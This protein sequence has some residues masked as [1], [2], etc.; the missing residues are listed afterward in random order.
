MINDILTKWV[1]PE[2]SGTRVYT[3][4]ICYHIP[5]RQLAIITASQWEIYNDV[6]ILEWQHFRTGPSFNAACAGMFGRFGVRI[7]DYQTGMELW[8]GFEPKNFNNRTF[9]QE[10]LWQAEADKPLAVK[11]QE[12]YEAWRKA[13]PESFTS[14][15]TALAA[16]KHGENV[17]PRKKRARPVPNVTPNSETSESSKARDGSTSEPSL[18]M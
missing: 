11:R 6:P 10:Q 16:V 5:K 13:N 4:A 2:A 7:V 12:N 14:E 1:R 3:H 9:S 15:N 18:P 17:K 8:E